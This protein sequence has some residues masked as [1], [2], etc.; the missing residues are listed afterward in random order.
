M[1]AGHQ[2]LLHLGRQTTDK[3]KTFFFPKTLS[4]VILVF[5]RLNQSSI[6]STAVRA[7][8]VQ[9][10]TDAMKAE[11]NQRISPSRN[12][13]FVMETRN[14]VMEMQKAKV[15]KVTTNGDLRRYPTT[16]RGHGCELQC[17]PMVLQSKLTQIWIKPDS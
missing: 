17:N 9:M 2:N 12:H 11:K 15:S 3:I 7:T 4:A 1:Q 5:I 14:N 6:C 16:Y 13:G 10:R 8:D